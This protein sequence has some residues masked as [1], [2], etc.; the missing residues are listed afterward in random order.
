M[1]KFSPSI[2]S[3]SSKYKLIKSGTSEYNKIMEEA[4]F[5]SGSLDKRRQ[6]IS[7]YQEDHQEEN[8][9]NKMEEENQSHFLILPFEDACQLMSQHKNVPFIQLDKIIYL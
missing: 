3:F 2:I 6:E 8:N 4:N 1:T 5:F 9:N 7:D